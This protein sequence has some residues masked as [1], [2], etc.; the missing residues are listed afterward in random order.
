MGK[1]FDAGTLPNTTFVENTIESFHEA[2]MRGAQMVEF[3]IVLTKDKIPIVYHDFIFCLDQIADK[4]SNNYLSI[5]VN[6]LTYEEVKQNRVIFFSLWKYI[7]LNLFQK[8]SFYYP[9]FR[10]YYLKISHLINLRFFKDL[11]PQNN[12]KRHENALTRSQRLFH[13]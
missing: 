10:M 1:T 8:Q 4:Q 9:G 11:F 2:Y 6:Q 13:E 12:E 5:A 3:D 7:Y